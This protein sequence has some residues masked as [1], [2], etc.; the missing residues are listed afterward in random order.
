MAT[1]KYTGPDPAANPDLVNEAY[2]TTTKSMDLDST[3]VDARITAGYSTYA[4]VTYVDSQDALNATKAYIDAG[5]ATRLHLAQRDVANG[6][7]GL[8]A[9]GKVLP[10]KIN[11]PNNQRWPRAFWSPTSYNGSDVNA[12]TETTVYTCPVTD[13]GFTYKLAIFGNLNCYPSIDGE[14]PIVRVRQGSTSGPIVAIGN[15][16]TESYQTSTGLVSSDLFERVSSTDLG[17]TLWDQ[18]TTLAV[19]TPGPAKISTTDGHNATWTGTSNYMLARRIAGGDAVTQTSDQAVTM[20]WSDPGSDLEGGKRGADYNPTGYPMHFLCARISS[21]NQKFIY[22]GA[23]SMGDSGYLTMGYTYSGV[24]GAVLG[25]LGAPDGYLGYHFSPW[26]WSIS[27]VQ[28]SQGDVWRLSCIGTQIKLD[29]LVGNTTGNFIT[30][31]D[32][33]HESDDPANKGW[34]FMAGDPYDGSQ[35]EIVGDIARIDIEDANYVSSVVDVSIVPVV[36]QT[37]LTGATTLYVQLVRSGAA[38]TVTAT[39]TLPNL[40]VSAIPA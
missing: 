2:V 34:G 23:G 13:P 14:Y 16:A 38:S 11:V 36:S 26:T 21:D 24:T 22:A 9:T 29:K 6:I 37:P 20:T 12:T 5:D 40:W 17:P 25:G 1:L 27:A 15:G 7:A 8:D 10:G 4:N 39:S 30:V 18:S 3:A 31:A 28:V 19:G 33:S 35:G 32:T